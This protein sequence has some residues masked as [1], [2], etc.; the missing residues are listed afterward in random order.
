M[1]IFNIALVLFI[2]VIVSCAIGHFWIFICD[3]FFKGLKKIFHIRK[4]EKIN[5][6]PIVESNEQISKNNK[7]N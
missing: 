5:W 2:L 7:E 1:D 3:F 4:K 6:H